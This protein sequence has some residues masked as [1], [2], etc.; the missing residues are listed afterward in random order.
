MQP[1]LQNQQ[2]L[3]HLKAAST[4]LNN[5]LRRYNIHTE[6]LS[7]QTQQASMLKHTALAA[8]TS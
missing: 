4:S 5:M 3:L 2:Q 1:Q 6:N 7:K 8:V